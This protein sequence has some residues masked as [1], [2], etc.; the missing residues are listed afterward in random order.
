MRIIPNRK[1]VPGTT[2]TWFQSCSPE[3]GAL[4]QLEA[5]IKSKNDERFV[6]AYKFSLE[7]C[8]AC[9]K[10]ADK[11]YLQPQIP[12]GPATQIVNFDPNAKWPL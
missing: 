1:T 11:P 3:N 4:K 9:H 8:Y 6:A 12:T 5:A 2:S 7:S 10:A